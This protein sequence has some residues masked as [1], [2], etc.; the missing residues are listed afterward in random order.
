MSNAVKS[1]EVNKKLPTPEYFACVSNPRF[2][3]NVYEPEADTF[4]FLD[5]LEKDKALLYALQPKRCV[6][7]GCGSGTVITFLH[8]LFAFMEPARHATQSTNAMTPACADAADTATSNNPPP[9]AVN[10]SSST[11]LSPEG[12][13]SSSSFSCREI[14]FVAVDVNPMALE[15]AE[16]TWRE[17]GTK[18]FDGA[19]KVKRQ[20]CSDDVIRTSPCC[21]NPVAEGVVGAVSASE[22]GTMSSTDDTHACTL[23]LLEGDLLT[24]V[25]HFLCASSFSPPCPLLEN[26]VSG[27][28]GVTCDVILFNPPYVPTSMEELEDAILK[29]DVITAA[30]CGGIKGRVVLDRFLSSLPTYLSC[31]GVCYVVLIRENDV[32]DVKRFVLEAFAEHAAA[33]KKQE[34]VTFES[35]IER[36]TGEHLGVYRIKREKAFS[37]S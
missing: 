37:S 12:L 28:G 8:T 9:N 1:A 13:P 4:L 14:C 5:A 34:V 10:L 16:T 23:H 27:S 19:F 20:G 36:Y 33:M 25:D 22:Y 24:P 21:C 11:W 15:A 26:A 2:R 32:E 18:Q 6:E 30:W 29:K 7:I 31:P 35:V 3:H 17:T